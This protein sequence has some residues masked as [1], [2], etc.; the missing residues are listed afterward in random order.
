[1]KLH[2]NSKAYKARITAL[3]KGRAARSR[4]AKLRR[5]ENNRPEV[6]PEQPGGTFTLNVPWAFI[7]TPALIAELGRRFAE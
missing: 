3:A 4:N 2:K 7:S 1:M 6:R 5:E